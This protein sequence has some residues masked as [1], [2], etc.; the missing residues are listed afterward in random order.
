MRRNFAITLAIGCLTIGWAQSASAAPRILTRSEWGA[1][2][3]LLLTTS[4]EQK[5]AENQVPADEGNSV[6]ERVK[7]CTEAQQNY[8]QEFRAARTVKENAQGGKLRWPQS[9]SPSVKMIVVHHTAQTLRDDPRTPLERM[10]ALYLYHAKTLGWGDIGYHFIIDEDGTI[11]EGRAG[12]DNVIGGHAYCANVGTIGVA[13]MGNFETEEPSQIQVLSL[14]WLLKNLT[15]RYGLDPQH[16][17]KFHGDPKE[18]IVGH[19]DVVS[20]ACPGYFLAGVLN[21]V[22]QHVA[23]GDITA[24]VSFPPPLNENYVDRT[25]ARRSERLKT[26]KIDLTAPTLTVIGDS[27][28]PVRPGS[29]VTVS[30][31]FRAGGSSVQRRARIASVMRSSQRIGIWQLLDQENMRIRQEI[32]APRLIHEGEVETIRL[33]I[34]VPEIP[35]TYSVDIGPVTIT[36]DA[37][38]RRTRSPV[39]EPV[40]MTSTETDRINI[41]TPGAQRA[42]QSSISSASSV[43][44]PL[45]RIRLTTRE[46]GAASCSAYDLAS[47]KNHYRGAVTCTV[48]GGKAALINDVDL[49]QYLA[50]LSEEP[51]TEPYEK[52]RAFAIAARSYAAFYLDGQNRKFP[53]M[54]YDGDDSPARFQSY[55]GM[56]AE[57]ANPRWVRA[58]KTTAGQVLT[59]NGGI[60]KA[61]YFSS[62]DGRTRTP[63]ENGWKNFPFAEVFVSKADPW[64]TGLPLAGHGVG[65]S[66]CGAKGQANEG[67]TAEQILQY[68]YPGTTMEGLTK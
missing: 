24:H 45:I 17:I 34:Q 18:V 49:E 30:L 28:V 61:A 10:R 57:R 37:Q 46:T 33:R 13:L 23:N 11:Y 3:S 40:P 7:Q 48:I 6:A 27:S 65:M 14:Q 12:G 36:L 41:P 59:V 35:A 58:V 55:A 42:T 9:Y 5:Q 52:Q 39:S 50:G 21:Q 29:Q 64:C 62:D 16:T 25:D 38:G 68:Y 44:S 67:K 15:N 2:E 20:T 1:D 56:S 31:L 47:L 19:R 66:G 63:A 53:G 32:F 22:R 51:D 43:S 4:E 60:V 54:P 8:P 26:L